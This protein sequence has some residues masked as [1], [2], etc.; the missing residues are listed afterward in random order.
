[1]KRGISVTIR[2]AVIAAAAVVVSAR[3]PAAAGER[4]L[5]VREVRAAIRSGEAVRPA[6]VR[7]SLDETGEVIGLTLCLHDER[8]VWRAVVLTR[9]GRVSDRLVNARTG[10][11]VR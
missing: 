6:A 4:C 7:A 8:L 10:A 1:M 2:A 5:D 11:L 9:N 3:A